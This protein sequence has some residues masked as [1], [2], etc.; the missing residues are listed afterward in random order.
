MAKRR[1]MVRYRVKPERVEEH[2]ALVRAVFAELAEKAPAGI[3]YA[4]YKQPDGT[5]FVHVALLEGDGNP[6][7]AI[8]AFRAFTAKIAER[9]D[10]PPA[11]FD[12][13]EIGAYGL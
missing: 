6:L 8:E 2:E 7:Q 4:A 3:R 13:A 9:C 11:T 5:S 12:L 10:E 1:V